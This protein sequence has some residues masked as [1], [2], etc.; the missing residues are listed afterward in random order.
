LP[1]PQASKR[2]ASDKY[3]IVEAR[4]V[5]GTG[6]VIRQSFCPQKKRRWLPG[7]KKLTRFVPYISRCSP[8]GLPGFYTDH[9]ATLEQAEQRI[10]LDIEKSKEE[11]TK[12]VIMHD[13]HQP[14]ILS[15]WNLNGRPE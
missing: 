10:Q 12:L 3:R 11:H 15:D 5:D 14:L 6:K 8:S 9:Y 4:V 2:M 7:W 13:Y 1:P